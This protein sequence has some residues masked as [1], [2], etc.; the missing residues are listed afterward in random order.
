[1]S[2]LVDVLLFDNFISTNEDGHFE[3][4]FSKLSLNHA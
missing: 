3:L 1:M 4:S 2:F